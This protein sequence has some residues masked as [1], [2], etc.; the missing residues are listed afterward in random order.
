MMPELSLS[1]PGVLSMESL[2][3]G[4]YE[5]FGE[6]I[7]EEGVDVVAS[8]HNTNG[9]KVN[10]LPVTIF[11]HSHLV[12]DPAEMLI[13]PGALFQVRTIGG[14]VL[15]TK[16][17][18]EYKIN[19]QSIHP[20]YK[21]SHRKVI[22]LD[23]RGV[24]KGIVYGSVTINITVH[25]NPT[26][27]EVR[28]AIIHV[29]DISHLSAREDRIHLYNNT[30]FPL[31][32]HY[33]STY[34][35]VTPLGMQSPHVQ[36]EHSVENM[37][38][39]DTTHTSL[40]STG[41]AAF[42]LSSK[43]GVS[44]ISTAYS[45]SHTKLPNYNHK[46]RV[47]MY[48][49]YP[50]G[51]A[52]FNPDAIVIPPSTTFELEPTREL[53]EASSCCNEEVVTIDVLSQTIHSGMN[54]GSTSIKL[55]SITGDTYYQTVKVAT[56]HYLMID[57]SSMIQIP[58]GRKRVPIP[59]FAL[60]EHGEAFSSLGDL[61]IV[62]RQNYYESIHLEIDADRQVL[63]IT[64]LNT[65]NTTVSL[66]SP[67]IQHGLYFKVN[68][69]S[70][71]R[72]SNPYLVVGDRVKFDIA[73]D[74][75]H[76]GSWSADHLQIVD[77]IKGDIVAYKPGRGDLIF[78]GPGFHASTQVTVHDVSDL[79]VPTKL[80]QFKVYVNHEEQC[81]YKI[82]LNV[83]DESGED[84]PMVSSNPHVSRQLTVVCESLSPSLYSSSSSIDEYGRP[85]CVVRPSSSL[86]VLDAQRADIRVTVSTGSTKMP[87][88]RTY[89]FELIGVQ[90]S[91]G[92]YPRCSDQSIATVKEASFI[93]SSDIYIILI[94]LVLSTLV[95]FYGS[96]ISTFLF[97]KQSSS[98][99]LRSPTSTTTQR[100]GKPVY[101]FNIMA[102]D[103]GE[104]SD[105]DVRFSHSPRTAFRPY[106]Y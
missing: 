99:T 4:E 25:Y 30:Q 1:I 29:V 58:L 105:E 94:I 92:Q 49:D 45:F 91:D 65:G 73:A 69:I 10:S 42:L 83:L 13:V 48:I 81:S 68:V 106:Q 46:S 37:D 104:S 34:G 70:T 60:S 24:V 39:L 51:L 19:S 75:S 101:R 7:F 52:H 93:T 8:V 23:K 18:I 89:S 61:S 100:Q 59:F 27:Y 3:D 85:H 77:A 98:P 38:V 56:P 26:Q 21:S 5:L 103:D 84:I 62:V 87:I 79:V 55:S 12:A 96:D 76:D 43:K 102:R 17:V 54:E 57:A 74:V 41:Y 11:V 95:F 2:G 66:T 53:Y 47:S 22:T 63:Y 82:D 15:K 36:V 20:S 50:F 72:P 71:I 67:S 28:Q 97:P 32:V 14:P 86:G 90:L 64:A 44:D 40:S 31:G 9:A 88:S 33:E 78:K 80:A 16:P 35:E 6:R